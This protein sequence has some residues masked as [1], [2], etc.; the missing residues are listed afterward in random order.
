M[1]KF[2]KSRTFWVNVAGLVIAGVQYESGSVVLPAD[3][4]VVLAALVNILL[5]F[6]T[7]SGVTV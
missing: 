1:K 4:Q 2:Y 6:R 5:R 7:D 3:A